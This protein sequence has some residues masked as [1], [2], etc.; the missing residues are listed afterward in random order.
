VNEQ[1][2]TLPPD[3]AHLVQTALSERGTPLTKPGFL[4]HSILQLSDFYLENPGRPRLTNCLLRFPPILL[5]LCHSI[6]S[7]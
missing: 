4:A 3:F 5:T 7:A 1:A 6:S 2:L